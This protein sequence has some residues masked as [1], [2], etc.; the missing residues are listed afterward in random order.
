MYSTHFLEEL[1]KGRTSG[2]L[3]LTLAL[4][5]LLGAAQPAQAQQKVGY[6]DS[7]YIL[8]RTPEYATVQQ[9]ID[10]K[11]QE[12]QAEVDQKREEAERLFQEYQARELL[13][14]NEERQRKQE[15][16]MRAEEEAERLRADYFGPEGQLFSEQEQLMRPI[17]EQI[18]E[19]VEEVATE[20]GYDYVFDKKGDFL[21]FYAR[22][23][24][25]L[26]DKVLREIG[27]DV[28]NP[29]SNN[30]GGRR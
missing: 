8:E 13:Y 27:I 26:S 20:E 25:D 23:Q 30:T 12:W 17:Q 2:L 29:S 10:R 7:E 11:A 22:E 16:I 3:A 14:T 19:A 18:L 1:V 24:Y 9:S 28:D 21:F 5:G 4:G 6:I 15:E